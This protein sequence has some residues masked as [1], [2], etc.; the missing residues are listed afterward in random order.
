ML[1]LVVSHEKLCERTERGMCVHVCLCVCVRVGGGDCKCMYVS[2][3]VYVCVNE[4]WG[5]EIVCGK[6]GESWMGVSLFHKFI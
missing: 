3:Y 5:E 6:V 4:K 1:S 2:V